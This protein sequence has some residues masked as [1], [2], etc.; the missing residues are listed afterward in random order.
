V[1]GA[2]CAHDLFLRSELSYGIGALIAAA[3]MVVCL[4][5]RMRSGMPTDA[6]QRLV[7]NI[8]HEPLKL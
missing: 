6:M 8:A 2:F 7:E 3:A 4:G 1:V 5:V